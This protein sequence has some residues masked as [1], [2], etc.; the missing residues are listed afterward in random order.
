MGAAK[1]LISRI[2]RKAINNRQVKQA[3]KKGANTVL[4]QFAPHAGRRLQKGDGSIM[5]TYNII[6][7]GLKKL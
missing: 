2:G 3:Y 4:Q 7:N 6:R 5:K 1:D